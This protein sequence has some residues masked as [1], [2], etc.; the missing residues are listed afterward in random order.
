MLERFTDRARKVMAL[1]NQEAARFNHDYIGTEHVL[2]ALFKDAGGVAASVLKALGVDAQRIRL[3]VEKVVGRGPDMVTMG[4]LPQTPRVKR[5]I[6][7]ALAEA[8]ELQHAYV[9]TEHLL[10]GLL[11]EVDGVAATALSQ[12]GVRLDDARRSVLELLDA[13]PAGDR[14]SLSTNTEL[15]TLTGPLATA[16]LTTALDH[17]I[18]V[19]E[20]PR[21]AL[22]DAEVPAAGVR[23]HAQLAAARAL[24]D[25][26]RQ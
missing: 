5:V 25:L 6:E 12:S 26:L 19:H 10:L 20:R 9:G 8:R 13:T 3:E 1:A 16:R 18:D 7:H 21:D 14:F 2:L 24:L 23:R 15:S 4:K 17:W 11:R 22:A